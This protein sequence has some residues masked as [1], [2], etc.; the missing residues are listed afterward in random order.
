M[1]ERTDR[2]LNALW[3]HGFDAETPEDA[4]YCDEIALLSNEIEE[5]EADRARLEWMA[6]N[7]VAVAEG[8][9]GGFYL[10]LRTRVT[11]VTDDWR[12]AIDAAMHPQSGGEG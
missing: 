11:E 10:I 2:L 8:H 4:G 9:R 7:R 3:K 12:E 6:M 5:L 1:S